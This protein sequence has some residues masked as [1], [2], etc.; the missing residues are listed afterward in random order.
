MNRR[1]IVKQNGFKDCGPS[2]LLSIMKYYGL[3]ASHEE[4]TYLLKTTNEGTNAF[5]IINGAKSFGFDGYGIKCTY[6]EIIN[7]QIKLPIIC[8]VLKN[9]MYHFIVIYEV[10]KSYLVVMDPSSNITKLSY[11][12]FKNMY[13]GVSLVIYPV[14]LINNV[15]T[16]KKIGSY[17]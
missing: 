5:N 11:D 7:N 17:I 12:D 2:C 4:V 13:L 15:N 8:H 6:E 3:E 10:K 14:K 9:N 1:V 16:H